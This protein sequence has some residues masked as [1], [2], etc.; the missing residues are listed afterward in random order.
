[1]FV[2]SLL[3]KVS[4]FSIKSP[5]SLVFK[6]CDVN[7]ISLGLSFI[8]SN[9]PFCM[10]IEIFLILDLHNMTIKLNYCICIF[11]INRRGCN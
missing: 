11:E 3:F 1:M 9:L 2:L 8:P 7:C 4:P 6:D 5:R 10:I